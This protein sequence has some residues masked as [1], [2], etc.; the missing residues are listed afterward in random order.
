M[1]ALPALLLICSLFVGTGAAV[2]AEE[3]SRAT[4]VATAVAELKKSHNERAVAKCETVETRVKTR[5]EE[6]RA[7]G[8]KIS[9]GDQVVLKG[10]PKAV[11]GTVSEI[12]KN[13]GTF[14]LVYVR[15]PY[16]VFEKEIF[17]V[18]Q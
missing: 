8:S 9:V 6:V 3:K 12:T 16:N 14:S 13:E 15:A 18:L 4:A 7:A 10:Y 2:H 1:K 11:V 5:S 17:Y